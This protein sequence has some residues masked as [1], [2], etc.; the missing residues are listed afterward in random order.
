[1]AQ[2]FVKTTFPLVA[3][4]E[5]VGVL[6]AGARGSEK[7]YGRNPFAERT[8]KAVETLGR[9]GAL[10][11]GLQLATKRDR[12]FAWVVFC[13]ASLQ[14]LVK[15]FAWNLSLY[16]CLRSA[17]K[18]LRDHRVAYHLRPELIFASHCLHNGLLTQ[19]AELIE[20]SYLKLW[21]RV[22]PGYSSVQDWY[23]EFHS[24]VSKGRQRYLL[25]QVG[26][27]RLKKIPGKVVLA[28]RMQL[29]FVAALYVVPSL[30][31]FKSTTKKHFG[32][33]TSAINFVKDLAVRIVRTSVVLSC[34]PYC[35]TEFPCLYDYIT[36]PKGQTEPVRRAPVLH[37]TLAS[38]VSTAVFLAEP[39][40]RL[41]MMVVYTHWRVA[42]AFI[43]K[44]RSSVSL[45]DP[46]TE[47]KKQKHQDNMLAAAFTGLAAGFCAL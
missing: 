26:E 18:A 2:S 35:L 11:L 42:E 1:M 6:A 39:E 19:K 3:G 15:A 24:D 9:V 17:A 7:G 27:E 28:C 46:F 32:S 45:A 5:L 47:E 41:N 4:G 37:S 21:L 12:R 22:T 30:I 29:P 20:P 10:Y 8:R 13:G 14:A 43:R 34:L 33:S 16:F 31:F 38:L 44:I 23:E 40:G 25:Q 36:R